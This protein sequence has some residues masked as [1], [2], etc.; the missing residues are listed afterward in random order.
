MEEEEIRVLDTDVFITDDFDLD[1]EF[2][3]CL[4][5]GERIEAGPGRQVA[6]INFVLSGGRCTDPFF[7]DPDLADQPEKLRLAFID[8]IILQCSID[9][10]SELDIQAALCGSFRPFRPE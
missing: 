1:W 9:Y 6:W 3:I 5:T 10:Y 2:Y 8:R 4:V 7:I